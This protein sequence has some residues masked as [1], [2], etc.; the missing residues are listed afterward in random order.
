MYFGLGDFTPDIW[1]AIGYGFGGMV[2]HLFGRENLI[3]PPEKETRTITFYAAGT[4]FSAFHIGAWN[5]ESP[6]SIVQTLW[7]I[8]ALTATSTGPAA[9]FSIHFYL[10]I[11]KPKFP[12]EFVAKLYMFCCFY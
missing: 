10:I 1:K 8:S 3:Y 12:G 5:L 2:G 11:L 6:S 9:I 4:I 7:R